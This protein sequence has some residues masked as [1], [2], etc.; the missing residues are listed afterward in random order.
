MVSSFRATLGQRVWLMCVDEGLHFNPEAYDLLL[1]ELMNLIRETWPDQ[2]PEK[3][4]YVLP[5]WQIAP[6]IANPK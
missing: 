1:E 4:P 2:D 3:L 5:S 6:T